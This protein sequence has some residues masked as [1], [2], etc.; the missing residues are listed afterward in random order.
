MEDMPDGLI[1]ISHALLCQIKPYF[2]IEA[3]QLLI[4]KGMNVQQL[5][6]III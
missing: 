6:N 4:S 2:T 3:Y 5:Y 1:N